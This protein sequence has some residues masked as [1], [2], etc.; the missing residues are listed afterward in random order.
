MWWLPLA[1]ETYTTCPAGVHDSTFLRG[2]RCGVATPSC[3]ASA[4]LPRGTIQRSDTVVDWS[5][6]SA[7]ESAVR[8]TEEYTFRSLVMLRA[9]PSGYEMYRS[10]EA[11]PISSL[12]CA[13]KPSPLRS[14]RSPLTPYHF[15]LVKVFSEP[16][17]AVKVK[18]YQ[19]KQR[20]SPAG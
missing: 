1:R 14:Q 19:R 6:T 12:T 20:K 10:W 4:A 3:L 11:E 2:P 16:P 8:L 5:V 7:L 15:C 17:F 13:T 9:S 18:M